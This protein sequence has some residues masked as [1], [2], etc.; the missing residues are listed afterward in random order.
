MRKQKHTFIGM[1]ATEGNSAFRKE[2]FSVGMLYTVTLVALEIIIHRGWKEC[3]SEGSCR[4]HRSRG[5]MPMLNSS[6][7][8]FL[9]GQSRCCSI[10]LPEQGSRR[11]WASTTSVRYPGN[12]SI[13]L[14]GNT[15]LLWQSFRE[16]WPKTNKEIFLGFS[17]LLQERDRLSQPKAM[18]RRQED[19]QGPLGS[20]DLLKAVRDAGRGSGWGQSQELGYTEVPK[21]SGGTDL[22]AGRCDLSQLACSASFPV[23]VESTAS[24][25][26][27]WGLTHLKLRSSFLSQR[28]H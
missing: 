13:R 8:K 4:M 22:T 17:Q 26:R 1:K 25:F 28:E 2:P 20:A 18:V 15:S 21:A 6:Q 24:P 7:G 14:I 16:H 5:A 3:S 23:G 19:P 9:M 11:P 10:C 27:S 12:K